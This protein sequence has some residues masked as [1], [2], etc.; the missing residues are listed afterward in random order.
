MPSLARN[1]TTGAEARIPFDALRG[2]EAPLFHVVAH[3]VADHHVAARHIA[4]H[5][6]AAH[7]IAAH[8]I[9]AHHIAAYG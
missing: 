7:H 2:A 9:A 8:H 5:H 3:R 4:A 1:A 6:I